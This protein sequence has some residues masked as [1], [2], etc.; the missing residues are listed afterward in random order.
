MS[1]AARRFACVVLAAFATPATAATSKA[2]ICHWDAN[3]ARVSSVATSSVESHFAQHGDSYPSQY[4]RDSDGDGFGDPS[5]LTDRC[6]NVGYVANNTDCNDADAS[7]SPNAT[8]VRGD[9]I[10]NDCDPLTLDDEA[11]QDSSE[12]EVDSN[13]SDLGEY[14]CSFVPEAP[15]NVEAPLSNPSIASGGDLSVEVWYRLVLGAENPESPDAGAYNTSIAW[16][17]IS[18]AGEHV[19]VPPSPFEYGT[20]WLDLAS[21]GIGPGD[22][23]SLCL[24]LGYPDLPSG[25]WTLWTT[26]ID[27]EKGATLK[28][29]NAAIF[30]VP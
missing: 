26:L 9:G 18:E 29:C 25:N 23:V 28:S 22:Y 1:A 16:E 4:F 13:F 27:E 14:G 21:F 5:E 8:E 7:I 19:S 24:T 17:W 30:T 3:R 12:I 6:P 2:D 11:C 10:D 20:G 15:W